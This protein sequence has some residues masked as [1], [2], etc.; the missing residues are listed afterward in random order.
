MDDERKRE[1]KREK[2]NHSEQ[3]RARTRKSRENSQTLRKLLR[4][5]NIGIGICFD[6]CHELLHT[7]KIIYT[8]FDMHTEKQQTATATTWHALEQKSV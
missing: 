2:V 8:Q 4:N 1:R 6:G 5:F 7:Y 3:N